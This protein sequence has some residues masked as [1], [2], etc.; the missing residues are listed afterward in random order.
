[1]SERF[2]MLHGEDEDPDI[3]IVKNL[4]KKYKLDVEYHTRYLGQDVLDFV[5]REDDLEN[6][7]QAPD[8]VLLDI[9]LPGINGIEVLKRIRSIES[10]KHI[11][12]IILSG[13]SSEKD[14]KKCIELGCNGY[15]QKNENFEDFSIL[16][17]SIMESWIRIIQQNFV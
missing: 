10:V 11:P 15:V 3:E 6:Y 14:F 9:G 12:I 13:S 7:H 8:L 17:K 2:I 16:F 5:L 1:M 4:I